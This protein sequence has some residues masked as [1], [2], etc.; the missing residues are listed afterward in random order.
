MQRGQQAAALLSDLAVVGIAP[1]VTLSAAKGL[2]GGRARFFATL[3]MTGFARAHKQPPF[4]HHVL[5]GGR[6]HA[7]AVVFAVLEQNPRRTRH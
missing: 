2:L 3:R 5:A 1:H 7:E 4:P 6:L